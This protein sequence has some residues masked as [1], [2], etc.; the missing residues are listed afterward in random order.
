MD[1]LEKGETGRKLADKYGIITST[2]NDIKK[3][4][5]SMLLYTPK[6]DSEDGSKNRK[7]M[8]G[9]KNELSEEALYC[10]FLQKRSTGQ[11]ISGPLLCEQSIT[12][13]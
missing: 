9:L 4:T 3:I 6:L 12:V 1:S 11:P 5:D 2:K 10:W 7:M 13:K 8:K